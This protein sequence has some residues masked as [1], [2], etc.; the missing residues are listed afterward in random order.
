M[1]FV[2]LIAGYTWWQ[3][4]TVPTRDSSSVARVLEIVGVVSHARCKT[5]STPSTASWMDPSI[6]HV[7]EAAGGTG[8]EDSS[9]GPPGGVSVLRGRDKNLFAFASSSAS[10]KGTASPT[11]PGGHHQLQL[12][13]GLEPGGLGGHSMHGLH[14]QWATGL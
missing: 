11:S 12:G 4:G 7:R 3:G 8:S 2:V 6:S 1:L 5:A 9:S 10:D 14:A 13:D